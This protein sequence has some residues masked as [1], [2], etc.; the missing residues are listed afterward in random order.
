ML[1]EAPAALV[2]LI[3]AN[4]RLW[5]GEAEVFDVYFASP[6]RSAATDAHWLAGQC[7][8]ELV[9]GAGG[10]ITRV[11]LAG[12]GETSAR[13]EAALSDAV[14][15]V[16]LAHYAAFARAHAEAC[17]DLGEIARSG[18][19]GGDWPENA[20]LQSLRAL[21]R[22]AHDRIGERASAFTEGGYCTLYRAGMGLAGGSALD[23]AIAT[24]CARVFDDEWDHMLAG[25]AGLADEPLAAADWA[26]LERL[27]IAQS[28]A[29]IRMRNAQ[30][31]HPLA[32]S[33]IVVLERGEAAPVTFDYARAGLR[34]P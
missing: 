28:R 21:H 8:K 30:F 10:Q 15:R 13:I 29:R 26:L 4:A 1:R 6:R 24:A 16:E 34:A 3:D 18:R 27:T 23:D 11:V 12:S 20:T 17:R 7:F 32:E 22:R 5:G 9:D 33:R 25:I 19:V 2:G 31:G 14:V